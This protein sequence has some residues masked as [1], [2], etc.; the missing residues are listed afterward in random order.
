MAVGFLFLW[1]KNFSFYQF[2]KLLILLKIEI[3]LVH[4]SDN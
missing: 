2:V 1:E 4:E 3:N